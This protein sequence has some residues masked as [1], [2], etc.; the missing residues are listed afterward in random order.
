MAN[1]NTNN[2]TQELDKKKQANTS[3][4]GSA[5]KSIKNIGSF[6]V[7]VLI[8]VLLIVGYFI[9]GSIVLYECKLA[10]SNILPTSLEC[11][12]YTE[13]SPEIQKVLTNIF[14]TNT[15]PQE[16]VK[17][18]FPV[19]KYNSKNVILDMFRKYKEQ[20]KSNFLINYIIAIL[21]GL[22][23]YSNN[24]LTSFF[25]LLNG[26]PEIVIVLF[27][28]ILSAIYFGLAPIIGIFVFIYYYFAEMKWF[29]KVNA[30]AN[31]NTNTNVNSKPVWNDVNLIEPINYGSALFLVFVFFIL[32][33][34]LLFTVT[35]MLAIGTFY[36]CLL[37]SFGYKGEIDNKK[38]SIFTII[39]EMFKHYKVT[40][41]TVF[42][43]MII[44]SAFSNLG[45][46]SGVFS[47]LTVLLIYFN[48]IP[49]NIFESIKATNLTPL[50]SFEQ[51]YKKCDGTSSKPK[52]FFQN[53]ENFFDNKKGG[54]I[55]RE[56]KKLNKNMKG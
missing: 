13:T 56:L 2:D 42:S 31:A 44:I 17:L 1:T 49:I 30:N 27:G 54:G 3:S 16:S 52:T 25:N 12:P 24:A 14:I 28:P 9:L 19:D 36:I 34:I 51:A 43:I 4:S 18:S 50:S 20:P 48:F 33:W 53:F 55:G 7:S 32:F 45:A 40:M 46:V 41:T 21:E 15:E 26:A 38:A 8:T 39:Q 22:I 10:Q 37:M 5:N 11:Y 47:M 23:N 35:P 6:L 29:F